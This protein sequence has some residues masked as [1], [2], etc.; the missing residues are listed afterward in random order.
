MGGALAR[1]VLQLD[2][3]PAIVRVTFRGN[4]KLLGTG[5]SAWSS[6]GGGE[7]ERAAAYRSPEQR[8]GGSVDHRS[9]LYS[10]GVILFELLAGRLP[11]DGT[12]S[13]RPGESNPAVPDELDAIIA[14]AM[15]ERAEDRYQSAVPLVA[16]LRSLAAI[17]AVRSGDR[18]PPSLV[19]PGR[20]P[21]KQRR[22]GRWFRLFG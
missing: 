16:E 10:L 20:T 2:L 12:P 19:P 4:A 14:R 6:G 22:G 1:G 11:D 7:G 5:L 18:E 17:L 21:E 9:D 13:G 15:A 3:R 8:R